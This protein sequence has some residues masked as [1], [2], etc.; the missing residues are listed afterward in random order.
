MNIP[1][2]ERRLGIAAI[3]LTSLLWGT[4]GTAATFSSAGPLA[5]GAVALGI[6]GL[7]QGVVAI[8]SLRAESAK[9]RNHRGLILLGALA[10]A[11]YPLAF[12]SSM[13]LAGVAIGSV[14]S[15]A[16]A[17]IASGIINLV[18]DRRPLSRWWIVAVVLGVMGGALLTASKLGDPA[19]SAWGMIAGIALG[20]I[21]GA[22]YAVYSWVAQGVMRS[23]VSR[24]ASMG[25]VFGGGGILL[26]PVMV[27][28]GA[29]HFVSPQNMAVA[30]YMALV[31]MFIG[32]LLF[33]YGLTKVPASTATTVT[34]TEPAAAALL[35]MIVVGERLGPLGWIGLGVVGAAI[36]ILSVAPSSRPFAV[37]SSEF[38]TLE[39]YGAQQEDSERS[40]QR[41]HR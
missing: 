37:R 29:A 7:L 10:V 26:T 18:V 16:S 34:L 40:D 23:G 12:Y 32:Y 33:G 35:A 6:G 1:Q 22:A 9:L 39:Q 31:P 13:H 36:V 28:T 15:L 2:R 21:A 17:P 25:A 8:P 4:T 11:V 20:L 27:A 24:A 19:G 41:P 14:V 5:I 38:P 30:A 3:T